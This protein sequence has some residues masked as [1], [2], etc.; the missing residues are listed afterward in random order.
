MM[1]EGID[2]DGGECRA[3]ELYTGGKD[4]APYAEAGLPVS[5]S[6]NGK[7]LSPYAKG[8]ELVLAEDGKSAQGSYSVPSGSYSDNGAELSY[9]LAGENPHEDNPQ[10]TAE[11]NAKLGKY[12]EGAKEFGKGALD[13]G[14]RAVKG[15]GNAIETGIGRIGGSYKTD[16][17]SRARDLYETSKTLG[18]ARDVYYQGILKNKAQMQGYINQIEEITPSTMELMFDWM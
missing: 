17:A 15:V 7:E 11:R 10:E 3:M 5:Y 6:L 8:G 18:E 1:I 16:S 2:K 13:L 9:L 14:G 4:I 12:W